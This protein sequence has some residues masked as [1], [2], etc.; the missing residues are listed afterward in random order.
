MSLLRNLLKRPQPSGSVCIEYY[1]A[2][3]LWRRL[4]VTCS[5]WEHRN[6]TTHFYDRD[7]RLVFEIA[8]AWLSEP[9]RWYSMEG[10]L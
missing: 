4:Y 8:T 6:G 1:N 3:G 2:E 9:L 7:G 5:R 10:G